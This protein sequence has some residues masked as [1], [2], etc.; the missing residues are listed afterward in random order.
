MPPQFTPLSSIVE[1]Y[2]ND[3]DKL[4]DNPRASV[5]P[6]AT[7]FNDFVIAMSKT[8]PFADPI[9]KYLLPEDAAL[10]NQEK[11][12][13][14][15]TVYVAPIADYK[16]WVENY[17]RATGATFLLR[18]NKPS[19][20][21]DERAEYFCDRGGTYKSR[22]GQNPHVKARPQQKPSKKV[23][24]EAGIIIEVKGDVMKIKIKGHTAH[25]I[26]KHP[27]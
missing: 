1:S 21:C 3:M 20:D 27:S 5:Q 15:Y 24:C 12:D 25:T 9:P 10:L 14:G 13:H 11:N 4:I 22:A 2:G 6:L 26:G 8:R 17:G 18:S 23:G 19:S 16:V 7:V